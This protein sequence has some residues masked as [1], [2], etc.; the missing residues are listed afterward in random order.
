METELSETQVQATA[1]HWMCEIDYAWSGDQWEPVDNRH[2]LSPPFPSYDSHA[3]ALQDMNRAFDVW[4]LVGD[5]SYYRRKLVPA[6]DAFE[7][8][9][10][11]DS[12]LALYRLAVAYGM[13]ELD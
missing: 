11:H 12:A 8:E 2:G 1:L 6:L 7:E 9:V 3:A 5:K 13:P 10:G 4:N